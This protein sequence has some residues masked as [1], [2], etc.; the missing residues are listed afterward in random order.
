MSDEVESYGS[1]IRAVDLDVKKFLPE[2]LKNVPILN[3]ENSATT[4]VV[5]VSFVVRGREPND[6]DTRTL[7]DKLIALDE[8]FPILGFLADGHTISLFTLPQYPKAWLVF[9]FPHLL[10]GHVQQAVDAGLAL[11]EG[12]VSIPPPFPPEEMAAIEKHWQ[13]KLMAAAHA[14]LDT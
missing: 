4:Q 7:A 11:L 5:V 6:D 3:A 14:A 2:R 10:H 9:S 12:A 1:V 8:K 13:D